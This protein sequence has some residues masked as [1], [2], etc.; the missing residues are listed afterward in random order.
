MS[1]Y[2]GAFDQNAFSSAAFEF[3]STAPVSILGAIAAIEDIGGMTASISPAS[4]EFDAGDDVTLQFTVTRSGSAVNITNMT[5]RFVL[6]RGY[7]SAAVASTEVS[8]ETATADLTTPSSGVFT[9]S[10]DAMVTAGLIGTYRFEAEVVDA[11]SDK[12]SVA[13]GFLT[14]RRNLL[15]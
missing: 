3:G 7:G 5:P 8:P 4:L 14:F 6:K 13:R 9:I 1:F 12:Q 15:S 10:I 2:T 11:N